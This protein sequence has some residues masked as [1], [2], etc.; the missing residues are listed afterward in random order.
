MV[1]PALDRAGLEMVVVSLV[2][3]L[4]RLGH[5][6]GVVCIERAGEL[7]EQLLAEGVRIKVVPT[8]GLRTNVF[9]ANLANHFRQVAP[10][11]VHVHSGAWLKAVR[12]GRMASSGATIS[13]L[14]GIW[15]DPPWYV[16]AYS[17]I[18]AAQTDRIVAVSTSLSLHLVRAFRVSPAKI[19]VIENGV[20]A[21]WFSPAP[22]TGW[23]HRELGIDPA[24]R[25]VGTV[26]RLHSVKNH[27]LLIDAFAIVHD[28]LPSTVLVI[29]GE[30]SLRLKLE[31]RIASKGL[32]HA[33]FLP[34]VSSDVRA[35]YREFDLF[36]LSSVIEGTSISGLEAMAC[37][38]GTVATEVGG[39]ASL[40]GGGAH[41]T[42]VPSDDAEAMANAIL[43]LLSDDDKRLRLAVAARKDVVENHSEEAVARQYLQTY[44]RALDGRRSAVW[45]D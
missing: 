15:P 36:V 19:D 26:G 44:R 11:V 20:D 27:A 30:G 37:G 33:V 6:A 34:G 14:H 22:R 43:Q 8:P 42:L 16:P 25:I 23:L 32:G 38:V 45:H 5:D 41:G 21:T 7:G 12:A 40:L 4:G 13:T 24:N 39:N 9:P 2:R 18:A 17:A 29:V 1:V 10:H 35:Y 31:H 28:K 3:T